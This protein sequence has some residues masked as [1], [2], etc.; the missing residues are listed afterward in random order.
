[1]TGAEPTPKICLLCKYFSIDPGWP[2]VGVSPGSPFE[3]ECRKYH[4]TF[5]SRDD[6]RDLRKYMAKA[7]TCEDYV[8]HEEQP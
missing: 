4:W 1:M 2:G 6:E 5:G 3:V 8:H 7:E